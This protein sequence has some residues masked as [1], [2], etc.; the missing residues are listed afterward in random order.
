VENNNSS[1]PVLTVAPG[2]PTSTVWGG[3][4]NPH[5]QVPAL[6]GHPFPHAGGGRPAQLRNR[7]PRRATGAHRRRGRLG[8][9][10][11]SR[12]PQVRTP[13]DLRDGD[14]VC[15]RGGMNLSHPGNIS[16]RRHIEDKVGWMFHDSIHNGGRAYS[17]LSKMEKKALRNTI[18]DWVHNH[19]GGRFVSR[20][21]LPGPGNYGPWYEVSRET[22]QQKVSQLLRD[23]DI[24]LR[25]TTMMMIPPN[26]ML[27]AAAA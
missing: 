14:V 6:D 8:P 16:F 22:S 5:L 23:A 10:G 13:L 9:L 3:G 4:A 26:A 12:R 27:A 24:R 1:C 21:K 2:C 11:L 15:E 20:N 7:P 19:Q 18:L 17:D 25:R